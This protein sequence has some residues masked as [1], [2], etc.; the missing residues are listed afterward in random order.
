[1]LNGKPSSEEEAR[2]RKAE[3]ERAER[4]R[5][6]RLEKA[7][8]DRVLRDA[9]AFQQ[10][11]E[12]RKYVDAIRL[13][14]SSNGKASVDDVERWNQWALAQADRIDPAMKATFLASMQD[15]DDRVSE[16]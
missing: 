10:A 12:I 4:G 16:S 2:R 3:A 6:A 7:R 14:Q 13:T 9:L 15:E 8:I 11:N 5:Q 1:V